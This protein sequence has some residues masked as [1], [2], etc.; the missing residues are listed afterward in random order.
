MNT[1]LECFQEAD[2][3]Y[4]EIYQIRKAGFLPTH[5]G[6]G[7]WGR[8]ELSTAQAARIAQLTKERNRIYAKAKRLQKQGK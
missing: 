7:T 4:G 6:L 8:T 5:I 2:R 1:S 3:L